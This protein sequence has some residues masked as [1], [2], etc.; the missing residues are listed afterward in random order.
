MPTESTVERW[1]T[2][3]VELK[4]P[5]TGNPFLDV[6]FD[7]VFSQ[8]GREVRVPGFYDGEGTYRVRFMPDNDGEWTSD[9]RS[10]TAALDGKTGSFTVDRA[11][12]RATMARCASATA[13]TSPMPTARRTFPSAPPAMPGP[14]SRSRCRRRRSRRWGRRGFNKMRM[15][16]FPKD[17]PYNDNEPL[18]DVFQRGAD[19]KIDFDRPNPVALPAFRDAGRKRCATWASRPTSSSSTPTTAG[20]IA[21]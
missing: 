4:G 18:H 5:S 6:E 16:V 19:G 21:T 2:F 8:K 10:A 15:G 3:E 11:A 13:S 12:R 7:A 14:T 17:Y 20:A 1:G 9:T